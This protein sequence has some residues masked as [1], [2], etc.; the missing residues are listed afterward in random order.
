MFFRAQSE[1]AAGT[2]KAYEGK[3]LG[4]SWWPKQGWRDI[5]AHERPV[6]MSD[7]DPE[8]PL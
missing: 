7:K 6:L 1:A 4:E 8:P 5:G 3:G 2:L